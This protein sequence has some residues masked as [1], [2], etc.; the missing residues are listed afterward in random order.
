MENTKQTRREF[1]AD[2]TWSRREWK[3]DNTRS[4]RKHRLPCNYVE[5]NPDYD[6]LGHTGWR[7]STQVTSQ[8]TVY[9]TSRAP[10]SP[11]NICRID[12]RSSHANGATHLAHFH[13]STRHRGNYRQKI[14]G[15]TDISYTL[16]G[17]D[18]V[19]AGMRAFCTEWI[20]N[21]A[22]HVPSEAVTPD[23]TS[24][25]QIIKHCW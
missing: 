2:V 5:K 14:L 17:H 4:R 11:F 15:L 6:A 24:I 1:Q 25:L 7:A 12:S 16:R 19:I 21:G 23:S 13:L 22:V 10:L 8:Y 20:D 18:V 3:D 9:R